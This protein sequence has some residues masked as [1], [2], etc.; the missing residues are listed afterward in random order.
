MTKPEGG[1][2][3]LS[4]VEN[5]LKTLSYNEDQV[6]ILKST[7]PTGTTKAYATKYNLPNLVHCPEFLTAANAKYDFVNADRTIIGSPNW[8]PIAGD[9][10]VYRV[11][12]LFQ[13]QFPEIPVYPMLSDESE[14]VKYTANCFLAT[15]VAFFNSV[16]ILAEK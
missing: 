14:L 12:A 8:D 3:N 13:K 6:I 7:V 5:F 11:M 16:C 1:E 9:P 10:Y 4:I 15:K 2:A